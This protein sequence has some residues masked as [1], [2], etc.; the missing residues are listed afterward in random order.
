[1]EGLAEG[2]VLFGGTVGMV[3][4]DQRGGLAEVERRFQQAGGVFDAIARVH[5]GIYGEVAFQQPA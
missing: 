3:E 1:M 5:R 2:D 4:D